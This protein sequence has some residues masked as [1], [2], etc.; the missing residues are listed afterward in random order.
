MKNQ[1][2]LFI[3]IILLCNAVSAQNTDKTD[4]AYI[5]GLKVGDKYAKSKLIEVFGT[6]QKIEQDTEYPTFYTLYY[7]KD[8]FF[9]MDGEFYGCELETDKYSFCGKVRVGDS[10]SAIDELHGKSDK[11]ILN[12]GV[13]AGSIHW[14]PTNADPAEWE[15]LKVVFYYDRNERIA[16]IS[17]TVWFI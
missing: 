1:T 17:A 7:G 2:F 14:L 16:L 4:G 8:S 3:S 13:Y 10:I 11:R 5:G 12:S 6:P 15:W 9:W